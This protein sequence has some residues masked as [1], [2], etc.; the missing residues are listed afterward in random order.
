MLYFRDPPPHLG[1]PE[2]CLIPAWAFPWVG[3]NCGPVGDSPSQWKG[4]PLSQVTGE[5]EIV[6]HE[7]LLLIRWLGGR[8]LT[9][10]G[11]NSNW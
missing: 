3:I 8:S 11:L 4:R 7:H 1:G 6:G 5:Q 10:Q 2:T 9:F